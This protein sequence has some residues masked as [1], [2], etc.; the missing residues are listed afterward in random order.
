M[1]ALE[2]SKYG[3]KINNKPI[4]GG[5]AFCDGITLY[6]PSKYKMQKLSKYYM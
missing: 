6:A 3:Y 1:L 2:H 4:P 5:G